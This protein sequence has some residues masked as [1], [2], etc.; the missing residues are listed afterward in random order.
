V[1]E[2]GPLSA[3]VPVERTDLVSQDMNLIADLLGRLYVEHAALFRCEDPA[4]A[5]GEVRSATVSGLTAGLLRY[6]G[7]EYDAAL[8]AVEAPTAVAVTHGSGTITAAREEHCFARGGA[9]MVPADLPSAALQLDAG[10]ELLRVPW[11]VAGSL[12]EERT[13]LPAADLRFEAMAPVSAWR[14]GWPAGRYRAR[15]A[16]TTTPPRWDTCGRSGWSARTP[17]CGTRIRPPG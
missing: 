8:E 16:A 15:S 3:E 10:Y 4:R 6:G 12:A 13:S 5:Y 17:N 14:P 7:F 2:G 11:P 9:F 1:A